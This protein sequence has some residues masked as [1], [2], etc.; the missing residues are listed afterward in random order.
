MDFTSSEADDRTR[1][2]D[3]DVSHRDLIHQVAFDHHGRRLAT[4]SS[5][6]TLSVWDRGSDGTWT[7][8][9]SWKVGRIL[10]CSSSIPISVSCMY[11]Q[12]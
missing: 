9:A 2:F 10:H 4:C 7:K 1:P 5:D 8:A 12:I 3:F 6:M 11:I